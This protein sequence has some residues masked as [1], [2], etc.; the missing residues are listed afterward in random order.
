[1]TSKVSSERLPDSP[2]VK[3]VHVHHRGAWVQTLVRELRFWMPQGTAK[4]NK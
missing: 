3:K 4:I 2:V 1:M